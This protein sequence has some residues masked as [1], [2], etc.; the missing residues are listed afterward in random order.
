MS[1]FNSKKKFNVFT[2]ELLKLGGENMKPSKIMI[3]VLTV[4]LA[5]TMAVGCST[6]PAQP[7]IKY[8]E[9]AIDMTILFGAGAAG[10]VIGRKLADIASKELGQ[11]IVA[12]N[13]T[14]AGGAVGYQYVLG[15]PA[16]GYNIV[17]NSTSINVV[18]HQGNMPVDQPFDAF[19]GV[20]Q[21][22]KEAA[23]MAV[24]KDARWNTA[25]EFFA[26]AKENPGVVTVGNSGVGS[27]N[28][29]I[30]AAIEN[31]AGVQFKHIPMDAQQS[32]AALLGGQ[33]DAIVNMS[34]D[35]IQQ[36]QAGTM[37]PLVVVSDTRNAKLPD[38][39]TMIEL[40]YDVNLL[41]YRGIAVPKDT[42][43]QIVKI[44]E[45]AFVKAAESAEFKEFVEKYGVE[46]DVKNGA[47]FDA[48]M[49][50][51]DAEVAAIM[52]KIGIKKQ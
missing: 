43:P 45:A 24:A 37:K 14:G 48:L 26:Y 29:L 7:E 5:V 8:P 18:Y 19:V 47:D 10:D 12:N 11:P 46:V 28:H 6:A 52:D 23:A 9:K 36:V 39:P 27:F 2:S 4:L 44:L 51:T 1:K 35:I 50:K 17:W 15:T 30:A 16:D 22:T 34:F 40:G 33:V 3:I 25:E 38:V 41:M 49:A 13:R 32:T 42:D 21:S 31:A 20:A